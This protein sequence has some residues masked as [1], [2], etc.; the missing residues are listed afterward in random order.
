MTS[1]LVNNPARTLLTRASEKGRNSALVPVRR[2]FWSF[3][4]RVRIVQTPV[5]SYKLTRERFFWSPISSA[6][7]YCL[8]STKLWKSGHHSPLEWYFNGVKHWH[9]QFFT[10]PLPYQFKIAKFQPPLPTDKIFQR[11]PNTGIVN[12]ANCYY[13]M[14]STLQNSGHHSPLEWFFKGVQTR[15]LPILHIPMALWVQSCK[16]P[17][18]IAHWNDISMESWHC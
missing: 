10:L 7:S 15:A 1:L 3:F 16:I 18:T 9:C 17:A 5:R 13:L 11:G 2:S 4:I 6:H 12:F 8:M 14:S